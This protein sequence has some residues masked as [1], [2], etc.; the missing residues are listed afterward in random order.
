[1]SQDYLCDEITIVIASIV[2]LRGSSN[3]PKLILQGCIALPLAAAA[4]TGIFSDAICFVL[5]GVG[6]RAIPALAKHACIF[7]DYHITAAVQ[8]SSSHSS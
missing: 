3:D 7:C 1:V 8:C 2:V 6:A 4:L 5:A